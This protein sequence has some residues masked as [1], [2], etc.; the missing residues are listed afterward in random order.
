MRA[1]LHQSE[2]WDGEELGWA[3]SSCALMG[4][5][6]TTCLFISSKVREKTFE[7]S[8]CLVSECLMTTNVMC[9]VGF[10]SRLIFHVFCAKCCHLAFHDQRIKN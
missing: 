1:A 3:D 6:F 4:G 5:A 8:T 10:L 9:S 7:R 2:S